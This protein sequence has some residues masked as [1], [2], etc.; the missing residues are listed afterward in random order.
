MSKAHALNILNL[1]RLKKFKTKEKDLLI[2]N[3]YSAKKI[4][5]RVFSFVVKKKKCRLRRGEGILFP[6]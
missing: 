5:P 4:R 6:V 3:A 1:T 2:F